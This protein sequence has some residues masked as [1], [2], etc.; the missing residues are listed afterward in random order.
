[1]KQDAS[2]HDTSAGKDPL[3]Q[4]IARLLSVGVCAILLSVLCLKGAAVTEASAVFSL[5]T[6]LDLALHCFGKTAQVY[7]TVMSQVI[8]FRD[9]QHLW[10]C[11]VRLIQ[12]LVETIALFQLG[13][14][15]A[16]VP[17]AAL[18]AGVWAVSYTHLT[19]PTNREV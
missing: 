8:R 11:G 12:I 13:L 15:Y 19:L 14:T 6:C 4:G 10:L 5:S 2:L 16:L 1:M 17:Y 9:Y 7:R 3:L 18:R